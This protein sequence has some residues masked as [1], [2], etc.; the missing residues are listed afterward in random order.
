METM[1]RTFYDRILTDI[2]SDVD[3]VDPEDFRPC[4][5]TVL[6]VL[7]PPRKKVGRVVLPDSAIEVPNM[8][9][10]A[11]VP[12]DPVCPCRPGDAVIYRKDTQTHLPLGGRDDLIILGYCDDIASEIVGVIPAEIVEE[13]KIFDTEEVSSV[14]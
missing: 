12:D 10:V 13:K 5:G 11:A 1:E 2:A 9:R 4:A 14:E 3:C 6:A 8:A 7:P